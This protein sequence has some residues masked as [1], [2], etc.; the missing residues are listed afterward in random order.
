MTVKTDTAFQPD[1]L[2][3]ILN[4]FINENIPKE[5]LVDIGKAC[6]FNK[7]DM[8]VI[9]MSIFTKDITPK[10]QTA[11]SV[12]KKLKD[13]SKAGGSYFETLKSKKESEGLSGMF[14][15][16]KND[17]VN[18]AEETVTATKNAYYEAKEVLPEVKSAIIKFCDSV[19][20]DYS[21]LSTD[22]EKGRYILRMSVLMIILGG[23]FYY[24]NELPDSDIKIWG[25][26]RHRSYLS[27]SVF[28][29]LVVSSVVTVLLRSFEQAETKLT[30]K[31]EALS[32]LSDLKLML[33]LFK[34]GFGS[35]LAFHLLVDGLYQTGGTIRF[36]DL[37]GNYKG[38]LVRGTKIDDMAYTTIM[39]LFS[40][41][42]AE[43]KTA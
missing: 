36:H 29:M 38:V 20:Q 42:M 14:N 18:L 15:L 9:M 40:M 30:D 17:S 12:A 3:E 24:G 2:I 25:I 26:G 35:G 8:H 27:H 11:Q 39:G 31:P 4:K 5:A 41:K 10:I 7:D 21:S 6:L 16:L 33:N 13:F 23:S 43:T 37:S 19:S 22:E 34:T 1:Q 32:L 28:P